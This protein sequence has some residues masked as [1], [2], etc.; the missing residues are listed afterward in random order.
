ML[1]GLRLKFT[2]SRDAS[3]LAQKLLATGNAYLH[4][5]AP[6]DRVWGTG[7][8]AYVARTHGI[9]G[10]DLLGKALEEVRRELAMDAESGREIQ[11]A[12]RKVFG[13]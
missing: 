7:C 11:A 12:K 4:E 3:S 8:V 13:G 5:A 9:L 2:E 6:G 1:D 10:K